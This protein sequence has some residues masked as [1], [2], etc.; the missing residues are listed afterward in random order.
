VEH[1]DLASGAVVDHRA[2]EERD[3][4]VRLFDPGTILCEDLRRAHGG[5]E[6]ELVLVWDEDVD[7]LGAEPCRTLVDE[8]ALVRREERA[9]EV[10]PQRVPKVS[11]AGA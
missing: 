1:A 6:S 10:D 7:A 4:R 3:D 11:G 2:V 5:S 8:A 9:G